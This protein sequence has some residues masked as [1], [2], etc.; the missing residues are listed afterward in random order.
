MTDEMGRAIDIEV[1][2]G[3]QGALVTMYEKMDLTDRAQGLPPRTR[4]RIVS[5]L[6]TLIDASVLV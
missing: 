2:D 6:E 1:F 3:N 4:T 5:W